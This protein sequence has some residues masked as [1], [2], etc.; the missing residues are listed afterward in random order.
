M[1]E[2]LA[3]KC[4][5]IFGLGQGHTIE[6]LDKWEDYDKKHRPSV[7]PKPSGKIGPT[8]VLVNE[9]L[10]EKTVSV[11]E[12]MN[13]PLVRFAQHLCLKAGVDLGLPYLQRNGEIKIHNLGPKADNCARLIEICALAKKLKS[14]ANQIHEL[15]TVLFANH[16]GK[17]RLVIEGGGMDFLDLFIGLAAKGADISIYKDEDED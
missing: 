11:E 6:F 14:G 5:D 12:I 10:P 3:E 8:P 2:S 16:P 4:A 1:P 17:Y 15:A 7:H 9:T 13:S